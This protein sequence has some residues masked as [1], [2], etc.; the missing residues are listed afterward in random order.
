MARFEII[1]NERLPVEDALY[2]IAEEG[3]LYL[4]ER[5]LV[6]GTIAAEQAIGYH[7]GSDCTTTAVVADLELGLDE[8]LMFQ[9]AA[10]LKTALHGHESITHRETRSEFLG[11]MEKYNAT[12]MLLFGVEHAIGREPNSLRVRVATRPADV[13][14]RRFLKSAFANPK[15]T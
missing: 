6:L 8:G 12:Q 14:S 3:R 7:Y 4:A 11:V 10:E 15:Q 9:R 2:G 13:R 5:S 1:E